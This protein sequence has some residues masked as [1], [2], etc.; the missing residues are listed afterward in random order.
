[1]SGP[2]PPLTNFSAQALCAVGRLVAYQ[3]SLTLGTLVYSIARCLNVSAGTTDCEYP[4]QVVLLATVDRQSLC[5]KRLPSLKTG[6]YMCRHAIP[7][8]FENTALDGT[9]SHCNLC[10]DQH[11]ICMQRLNPPR[12][13]VHGKKIV[14]VS[15]QLGVLQAGREYDG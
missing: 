1:M 11:S 15:L 9:R 2:V 5:N 4:N 7:D 3:M 8:S 13:D 14:H 10:F 6:L 12:F